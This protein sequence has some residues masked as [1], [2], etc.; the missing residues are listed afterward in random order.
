MSI[1]VFVSAPYSDGD[2][3]VNV[4]AAIDAA[5]K[6]LENGFTPFLPHLFHFWHL[7]HPHDR[8]EWMKLDM[9][10]LRQCEALIRLPGNSPGADVE[11]QQAKR[12]GIPVYG[13]VTE[14][15]LAMSGT[16]AHGSMIREER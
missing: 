16:V 9:A 8:E 12:W 10:W 15:L 2:T 6:L 7:I 3:A 4:R 1:R 14:F 5:D 11:E 13:S